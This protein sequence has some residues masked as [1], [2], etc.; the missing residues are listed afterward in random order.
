M[1]R[2]VE[3]KLAPGKFHQLTWDGR[4]ANRGVPGDGAYEVRIGPVGHDGATVGRFEF[5][6]H[7]FPVAGP[8]TY[9][10]QFGTRAAAGACMR[11][12]T[13]PRPA[14]RR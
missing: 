1:R 9:G 7:V 4:R 6:D 14:G 10:D 11:A 2:Y 3:H 13:Y 8:H 5:H 12:R